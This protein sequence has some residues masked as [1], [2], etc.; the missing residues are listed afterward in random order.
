MAR[1]HKLGRVMRPLAAMG[2]WLPV[3]IGPAGCSP[4]PTTAVVKPASPSSFVKPPGEGDLVAIALKPEAE[5]RLGIVDRSK[6]ERRPVARSV[7]MGGDVV[8]PPGRSSIVSAPQTGTL[9]AAEGGAT[10]TPGLAVKK[11]QAI[12]TLLPIL[13]ADRAVL[14]PVE[15]V[16]FEA[17][18]AD[19]EGQLDAARPRFA[20]AKDSLERTDRLVKSHDVPPTA[21]VDARNT[22]DSAKAA[23]DAAERRWGIFQ[24]ALGSGAED[25]GKLAPLPLR[26]PADGILINVPVQVGQ[27]VPAGSILFEVANLDPVYV[28]VAV[29][30][31]EEES[32]AVDRDAAV[33]GLADAPGKPTRAARPVR[34]TPSANPLATTVDLYYEVENHE[35]KFRPGQRV[36]VTL[37][38]KGEAESLV[39]PYAAI[40]YDIN[41]GA[42]VYESLGKH[43][44]MRRRVVVDHI[45]GTDAVLAVGPRTGT[46]VVTD[47][48]AELFG[49]EFAGGK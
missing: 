34:T 47:G 21:L 18:R 23:L 9:V 15:R 37:P 45:A 39:V 38:M 41:G 8:V 5:T 4:K 16:N 3:A 11:G 43:N 36:G 10:I 20:M 35:G 26:A 14:T 42:W 1:L 28:R 27:Q 22:Y 31:G 2:A 48:A 24:K 7:T 33:G 40:L 49:T 25:A 46:K 17:S 19:A 12:F 32:V 30:V 29:F 6:V 44:Y 13:S